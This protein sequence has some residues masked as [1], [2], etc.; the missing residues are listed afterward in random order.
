[1]TS[2]ILDNQIRDKIEERNKQVDTIRKEKARIESYGA[3]HAFKVGE[4]SK[5]TVAELCSNNHYIIYAVFTAILRR[6][7]DPSIREEFISDLRRVSGQA[8]PEQIESLIRKYGF[9]SG[10]VQHL[11]EVS[12]ERALANKMGSNPISQATEEP[13]PNKISPN[14]PTPFIL[15][16][17]N[18]FRQSFQP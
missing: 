14:N 12:I 8:S 16:L 1:E 5:K 2:E 13:Q 17:F 3:R 9:G 4:A 15:D 11:F 7:S 18:I 6:L 10:L